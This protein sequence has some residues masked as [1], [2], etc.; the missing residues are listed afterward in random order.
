MFND[1]LTLEKQRSV[2]EAIG[3]YIIYL[4]F[5]IVSGV[6][7]ALIINILNPVLAEQEM[8]QRISFSIMIVHALEIFICSVLCVLI[9]RQKKR[10]KDLH[11]LL[12]VFLSVVGSMFLGGLTGLIFV[13]GLTM[14]KPN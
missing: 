8:G 7:V 3:F 9:L 4:L 14:L 12:V 2:R 1:L 6:I 11:L 13:A 5:A 10:L